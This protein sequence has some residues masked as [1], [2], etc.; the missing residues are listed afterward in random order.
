MVRVKASH[1]LVKTEAEAKEIMQKIKAGDDFAK[2][3]KLYSQ[4][5]SGNAGGDLGYFG[6]GQMVKPFEEACFKANAGDVLGPVKT[7][8][9]WHLIK[10]TDV[11][12]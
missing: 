5:P 3:A 10:V 11:K 7:Q 1:I 6:K 4:C 12:N 8:F 2:L 9:G